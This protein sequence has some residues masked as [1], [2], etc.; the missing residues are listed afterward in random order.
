[1]GKRRFDLFDEGTRSENLPHRSGMDPDG[2]LL[3]EIRKTSQ[4]LEEFFAPVFIEEAPC[5]KIGDR[6]QEKQVRDHVV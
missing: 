2:P 5:E 6:D 1:M 4:S 3:G